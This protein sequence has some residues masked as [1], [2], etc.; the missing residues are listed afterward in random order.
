MLSEFEYRPSARPSPIQAANP[1]KRPTRTNVKQKKRLADVVSPLF[2]SFSLFLRQKQLWT[3]SYMHARPT[4]SNHPLFPI[5][6][7]G[8]HIVPYASQ[9][10]YND[11][12]RGISAN[13]NK[14]ED[15]I[16]APARPSGIPTY[17]STL[18]TSVPTSYTQRNTRRAGKKATRYPRVSSSRQQGRG[19]L[20]PAMVI[21]S[22]SVP[23]RL[24][25]RLIGRTAFSQTPPTKVFQVFILS[26]SA[27]K[28]APE[29]DFTACYRTQH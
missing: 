9:P 13:K 20:A 21:S 14:K 17:L 24:V 10:K 28:G 1:S 25:D 29:D 26:F 3:T 12:P 6:G 11:F 5:E 19:P 7:G 8:C 16:S 18:P 15:R 22:E 27:C 2:L 4:L 23:S